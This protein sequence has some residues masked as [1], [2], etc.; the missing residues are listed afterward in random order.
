VCPSGAIARLSLEAKN[1]API[2]LA[3]FDASLCLLLEDRECDICARA[4]PYQAI[5]MVWSEEE[6]AALPVVD[7]DKC[8]GCG[9]CQVIC[10]GTNEWERENSEEPVAVRKAIEVH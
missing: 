6:Y 10:P 5:A 3:K 7:A 4:C 2:G 8:P 1:K 9:A